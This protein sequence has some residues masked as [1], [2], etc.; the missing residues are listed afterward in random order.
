MNKYLAYGLVFES[1]LDLSPLKPLVEDR[2]AD[3][4]V[5]VQNISDKGILNPDISLPFFQI[6]S[7]EVWLD[8]PDIC[9]LHISDGKEIVVDPCHSADAQTVRLFKGSIRVTSAAEQSRASRVMDG[10]SHSDKA[11]YTVINTSLLA[12]VII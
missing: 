1:A 9:R 4:S 3:V 5:R 7:N 12:R 6:G 10:D 2:P 8:I 11:K